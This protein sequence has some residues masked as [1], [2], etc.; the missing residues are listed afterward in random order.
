MCL[1]S[2]MLVSSTLILSRLYR[3]TREWD[4]FTCL[5]DLSCLVLNEV[6]SDLS[7]IEQ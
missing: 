3:L 1:F 5:S 6:E 4:N 2:I 7:H